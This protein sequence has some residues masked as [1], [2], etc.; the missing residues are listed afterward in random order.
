RPDA[1]RSGPRAGRW[2]R[3][4]A[5]GDHGLLHLGDR[6]GHL[7]AAGAR[8]GAVEGGAAAPHP[9]LGV[10][11]LQA[12]LAGVVAGV[13]DESVRVDDRG[14]AEVLPVGP[15]H[16]ARGGA[17]GAQDALGGVVEALPLLGGLQ[18]LPARLL[19]TG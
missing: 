14:R 6:L 15:E 2:S 13:E 10:Q 19:P 4:D 8:L 1:L 9:L 12:L 3:S 7:D 11:D 5:T 18:A 17:G 16:R